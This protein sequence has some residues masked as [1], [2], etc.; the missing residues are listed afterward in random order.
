MLRDQLQATA[1]LL[2][3]NMPLI[4]AITS[5]KQALP[6]LKVYFLTDEPYSRDQIQYFLDYFKITIFDGGQS[7]ASCQARKAS[8]ELYRKVAAEH[9][10]SNDFELK[11]NLHLGDSR[12]ADY[13][14]VRQNGGYALHYRPLRGRS[15]RTLAGALDA[16]IK[17]QPPID[18]FGDR[19]SAE[20]SRLGFLAKNCP[21]KTFLLT[22]EK[23]DELKFQ[24]ITLLPQSFT[25]ENIITAPGL[26]QT[27]LTSAL[28]WLLI[29][30]ADGRW[31]LRAIFSLIWALQPQP[32]ATTLEKRRAVYEF[33]FGKDYPTSNLI[34]EYRSDQ[35]FLEAFLQDFASA[36]PHYTDHLREAYASCAS[37]L[38]RN[39]ASV[40]LV[41][42]DP[43]EASARLF[44]EF[45]RLHGLSNPISGFT[46]SK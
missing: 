5:L 9:L 24:G 26:N 8:G 43:S 6:D 41:D 32:K 17:L 11:T 46:V 45:A 21:E 10:L 19:R 20:L 22:S 2:K 35:E 12:S 13:L 28:I 25:S 16:A 7:G 3:P 18:L 1:E 33:C 44:R 38:P 15:L 31:N 36:D 30:R 37:Y 34:L 40:T 39:D 23:A 4:Q 14:P 27:S 29:S 42:L